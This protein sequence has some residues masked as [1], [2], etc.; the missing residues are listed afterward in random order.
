MISELYEKCVKAGNKANKE[1]EIA[2][3][4]E[5]I[6]P[7][8]EKEAKEI[9][10]K[11]LKSFPKS[12]ELNQKLLNLIRAKIKSDTNTNLKSKGKQEENKISSEKEKENA[13]SNKI[14]SQSQT[15]MSGKKNNRNSIEENI[16]ETEINQRIKLSRFGDKFE[17]LRLSDN[18]GINRSLNR[19]GGYS[20]ITANIKNLNF[21]GLFL[22]ITKYQNTEKH[23]N[24]FE[25]QS[26]FYKFYKMRQ[27]QI[28]KK[29]IEMTNESKNN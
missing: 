24:P 1:K 17:S 12:S 28:K 22:D 18:H 15:K 9:L 26:S 3:I 20:I 2:K 29:I 21:D 4:V 13:K 25:G 11:L 14:R 10:A 23:K 16:A 19:F 5:I 8:G 7:L 27:S 6:I